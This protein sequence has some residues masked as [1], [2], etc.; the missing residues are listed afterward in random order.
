MDTRMFGVFDSALDDIPP[1]FH[2]FSSKR[3]MARLGSISFGTIL[4]PLVAG[5]VIQMGLRFG[6]GVVRAHRSLLRPGPQ[7]YSVFDEIFGHQG[8]VRNTSFFFGVT[9]L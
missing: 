2:E 9:S 5:D 3:S 4:V 7:V 6:D 1:G 8:P